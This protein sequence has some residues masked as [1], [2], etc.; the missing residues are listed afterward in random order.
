MT[1][2][3]AIFLLGGLLGFGG[4]FVARAWRD[5]RRGRALAVVVGVAAIGL[6]LAW[7]AVMVLVVGPS[8]R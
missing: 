6:F 8:L 7:Q 1:T 2:V 3:V 4:A 5:G